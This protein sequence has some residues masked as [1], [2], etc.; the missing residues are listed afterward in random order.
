MSISAAQAFGNRRVSAFYAELNAPFTQQLEANLAVRYDKYTGNG[1]F[2]A[3][4]PKVG[5]RYQPNSNLLFRATA[6]KAFRAPSLFET[7][8]AQQT[9]F[10]FGIQ[11]PVLCPE[12]NE[13][14]PDC[15]RDIRRV[16][17]GNP[18][19]KPEKSTAFT[20]GMVIEPMRDFSIAI[21]G[22][23]IDR[24][25]EIGAFLDQTLINVFPNDGN[26]VVRN[27]AGQIIQLNQVPVQLNKTKT[28]GVDLEVALKTN[29]GAAGMLTSKFGLSYVGS[30]KFTTIG[31][32]GLQTEAEFNGTYNQPRYRTS[33]DF[34]LNRGPG[35]CRSAVTASAAIPASARRIMC[36]RSKSGTWASPTPG[37]RT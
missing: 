2:A 6:S 25:D 3:T 19:L 5:V 28:W 26:I 35:K 33:W 23:K 32:D 8:P 11:D 7:S 16:A 1:S 10:S 31:D 37:S 22:W 4:S 20:L 27:A 21:D 9:S 30:Y 15:V 29:L 34:A 24:K 17:Q 18:E 14:N 36:R 12:F 13:D